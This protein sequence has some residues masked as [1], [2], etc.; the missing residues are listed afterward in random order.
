MSKGH[1]IV[2]KELK[3]LVLKIYVI[4]LKRVF[5]LVN[6]SNNVYVKISKVW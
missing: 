5:V 4:Y 3:S 6:S 1:I 2:F